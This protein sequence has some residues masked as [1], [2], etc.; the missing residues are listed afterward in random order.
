MTSTRDRILAAVR[1]G[2]GGPRRD[3]AAIAAEADTLL[4]EPG[5][6]RP[7][8]AAGTLVESFCVKA[9]VLGTT[10][11]QVAALDQ[12]PA[13]VG[14]YLAAHGLPPSAAIQQTAELASLR[15][16][17][18]AADAEVAPDQTAAVGLA[19]CGIAETGS[20]V[21]HAAPD[22][23]VLLAFLPLHHIVV[24]QA[25]CILPHLEDYAALLDDDGPHPRNAVLITGPSGTTDIEGSYVRGAHGP[26]FV[27]VI[28]VDELWDRA[29][30]GAFG[31]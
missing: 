30:P 9:E 1:S 12:V 11:D 23:P 10:T 6:I 14:R 22:T 16:D 21:V 5:T 31:T 17:T 2:L 7:G 4:A 18:A 20:I 28:L 13:A 27:H 19:R 3:P 29:T 24:L 25:G 26:G 8:L 15:W